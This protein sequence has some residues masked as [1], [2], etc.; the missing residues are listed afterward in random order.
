M[1]CK[2]GRFFKLTIAVGMLGLALG[3]LAGLNV[4]ISAIPTPGPIVGIV[5]DWTHH[6][7]VFSNPGTAAEALAEGRFEQWYRTVNNPR[8]IMQQ[9]KRNPL[10][11][12]M[13]S[14][15][16]FAARMA[17]LRPPTDFPDRDRRRRK[18]T[19][20]TL[21]KDWNVDIGSTAATQTGTFTASSGTGTVTVGSTILTASPG[22]AASQTT[23]INTN[24]VASGNTITI[25]NGASIL[26]LTASTP[27][28]QIDQ[29][30][31]GATP[32]NNSY[33]TIAGINYQF[34]T[35]N[36]S[37]TV[38]SGYCFIRTNGTTSTMVSELAS[39][40][41]NGSANG[42]G[43]GTGTWQ[44]GTSATQPSNGVTVYSSTSPDVDVQAK[45]MGSTGFTTGTNGT[46]RLT[47]TILTAAS[48]GTGGN[49]NW[50]SGAA[51]ASAATLATNIYNAMAGN[52]V[53]ITGTN[54]SSGVVT[55]TA[56][57]TGQAGNGI[58]VATTIP[59]GLTGG[60]FNGNLNGG[61]VGTTS[62]TNFATSTDSGSSATNLDNEAAALA[63][64][65]NTNVSGVTA[66]SNGAV[67]TVTYKTS[68]T[69]GNGLA[70][71]DTMATFSWGGAA[72]AG[73]GA[74][75]TVGSG[76]FPAK[77]S[78]N[79]TPSC[80]DIAVFNTSLAGSSTAATVMA[81]TNLY[82][83]CNS[84]TPTIAWAYNTTTNDTVNT[85]VVFNLQGNQIAFISTDG[86]HAYLNVLQFASGQG[87]AFNTPKDLTTTATNSG[88]A[89]HTC[90]QTAG[91][92]C[93]LR[94]EFAN[95]DNDTT[96]SPYYD[97]PDDLLWVGDAAGN[98]HE[99][100]GVF[101]GSVAEAGSP[102]PVSV[103]ATTALT[104]PVYYGGYVYVANNYVA[105][106]STAGARMYAITVSSGAVAESAQLTSTATANVG[107]TD[108]ALL[109]VANNYLYVA[110]AYDVQTGAN[111]P[112]SGIIRITTPGL[113]TVSEVWFPTGTA[114]VPAFTGTFDNTHYVSGGTTGYVSTCNISGGILYFNPISLAGFVSGSKTEYS[115]VTGDVYEEVATAAVTCSPQTEI[116][117]SN[118]DDYMFMSVA[119]HAD[120]AGGNSG[121]STGTAD[122]C[123]YSFQIGT[124]SGYTWTTAAAPGYG[125]Q[126]PQNTATTSS[127]TSGIIVDN[128]SA[129]P[130]SNIY[131]TTNATTNGT[132]C[133]NGDGCAI[134]V[135]QAAP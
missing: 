99:F 117:S 69:G 110:V 37:G 35:S 55:I 65:I 88:S 56:S 83:S 16:D 132:P 135:T 84:G 57:Q 30:A 11:Q 121:C 8:Y 38:T 104:S 75:G 119:S 85:S 71:T 31:F 81:V 51:A 87:T 124:S 12:E 40:I 98:V 14:A 76:N 52:S 46:T 47:I 133:S 115:G 82:S 93:L 126:I 15:P 64:A 96:S 4:L 33:V 19:E 120:Q 26:T 24:G 72:L 44:C 107:I 53:G 36:W 32:S 25:T 101:N 68:G 43:S 5:E 106:L 125:F 9:M 13:A 67:V 66:S 94:L 105:S 45:I 111:H 100:T 23:T 20:V 10:Q 122:A 34:K 79:S 41:T 73:G 1:S 74:G 42:T 131:F 77:F 48:D 103:G 127:S 91:N 90:T 130:G 102:W 108:G 109:D 21:S 63:S 116:L 7:V 80:S 134:Q 29:I 6:H 114:T 28:A 61:T 86:T 97:Y 39:A 95:D 112:S 128:S 50:W 89:Y 3:L 54:P 18:K 62:G 27:Q 49:F 2:H 113:G 22:T 123:L 70:T 60:A 59:S 78:F 118:G 129:S 92:T 17:L 58:S